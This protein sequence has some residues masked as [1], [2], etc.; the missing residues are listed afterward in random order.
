MKPSDIWK[1]GR[2]HLLSLRAF[3]SENEGKIKQSIYFW[4]L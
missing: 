1:G 2:V 4:K 3:I